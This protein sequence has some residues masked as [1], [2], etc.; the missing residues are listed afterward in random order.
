V[1]AASTVGLFA[2]VCGASGAGKDT[3]LSGAKAE[4]AGLRD[5]VFVRRT[6]TRPADAGG[7]DHA[8]V[9]EQEFAELERAGAF[10]LSW[11]AHGLA[12]GVPASVLG[13]L[14]SGCTVVCNI[15]RAV[16]VLAADKFPRFA[17]LEVTAEPEIIAARLAARGR[18][19]AGEIE[20]RQLR[21]VAG[22]SS[23]LTLYR[24]ANNGMPQ[25]AVGCFV[26]IVLSLSGRSAQ[27]A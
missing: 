17:L 2:G 12:Y 8:S 16:A 9:T 26:S 13:D 6:I 19:T 18:E 5:I 21:N 10:C 27:Q 7:E 3:I 14:A 1:I 22:W 23:G 15:S 4:L 24:V 11:R 25:D 20:S